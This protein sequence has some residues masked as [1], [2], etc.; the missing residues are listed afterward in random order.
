M[1]HVIFKLQDENYALGLDK[2]KEILVYSEVIITELFSEQK[3]VKGLM[4]LRGE[5]IPLIDLRILFGM[6]EKEYDENCVIIVIHTSEGKL[7]GIIVDNI[8]SILDLDTDK[9]VVAPDMGVS[10]DPQYING[11]V[12]LNRSEMTVL[13]D[14]DSLL[15]TEVIA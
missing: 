15:K 5:V 1:E 12:R 8:S 14:M 2:I 3:W 6:E 11:L 10:I 7:V 13:L 9:V 4:N